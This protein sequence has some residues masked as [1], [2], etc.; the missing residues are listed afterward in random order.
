MPT[1]KKKAVAPVQLP[2]GEAPAAREVVKS[3]AR[4]VVVDEETFACLV[5]LAEIGHVSV[6]E[7]V[8]KL[9]VREVAQLPPPPRA[10]GQGMPKKP[11]LRELAVSSGL[12]KCNDLTLFQRDHED[13]VE[14]LEPRFPGIRQMREYEVLELID[15]V[16]AGGTVTVD[17]APE[18]PAHDDCASD[19]DEKQRSP[20]DAAT[21]GY[22]RKLVFGVVG[23][24][25]K[26]VEAMRVASNLQFDAVEARLGTLEAA[27]DHRARDHVR[28]IM[29][30]LEF[31]TRRVAEMVLRGEVSS[32][33]IADRLEM[34]TAMVSVHKRRI[35]KAI[36]GV[37]A[38]S[39]GGGSAS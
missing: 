21:V 36:E 29:P 26:E 12:A 4:H 22:V 20:G 9:V 18:A 10:E 6:S 37:V 7:C 17:P 28:A 11:T 5:R 27:V 3:R 8:R 1:R 31:D 13:L 32:T 16:K 39:A 38:A 30:G 24:L 25:R 2:L 23:E 35:L 34:T 19:D 33:V 14:L 15:E